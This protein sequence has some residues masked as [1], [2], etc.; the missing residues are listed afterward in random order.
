MDPQGVAFPA[1]VMAL[2]VA[3]L[4]WHVSRARRGDAGPRDRWLGAVWAAVAVIAG[5]LVLARIAADEKA[6]AP[7]PDAGVVK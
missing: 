7:P 4:W 3:A 1:V 2:A 6:D 5:W